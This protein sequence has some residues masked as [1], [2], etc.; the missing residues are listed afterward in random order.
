MT[1]KMTHEMTEFTNGQNVWWCPGEGVLYFVEKLGR[2]VEFVFLETK[3]QWD[4]FTKTT[5][6]L[7]SDGAKEIKKQ[8]D[9]ELNIPSERMWR[10]L[11]LCID[12]GNLIGAIQMKF[13]GSLWAISRVDV[14]E[15]FRGKGLCTPFLRFSLENAKNGIHGI[16]QI[17]ISNASE[18]RGIACLCYLNAGIRAGFRVF[19]S[20]TK[21]FRENELTELTKDFCMERL[22]QGET[23]LLP[24][25]IL[26]QI[27]PL[28]G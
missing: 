26:Y 7:E 9:G 11:C 13:T 1:H 25:H 23:D 21:Y 14:I 22:K 10:K 17:S 6:V 12:N 5:R 4:N 16:K 18:T 27:E 3:E 20:K 15:A 8:S 19:M 2:H 24:D 28:H